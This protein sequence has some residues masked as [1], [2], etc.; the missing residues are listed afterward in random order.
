MD[1]LDFF[2]IID[3]NEPKMTQKITQK[4]LS[5]IQCVNQVGIT[6]KLEGSFSRE[7]VFTRIYG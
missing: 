7:T 3:I 6:V 1:F 4:I 2:K 5:F